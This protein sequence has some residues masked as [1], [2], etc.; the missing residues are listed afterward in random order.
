MSNW[1]S[2]PPMLLWC[3]S[4]R[5]ESDVFASLQ[6]GGHSTS[7]AVG[8]V[9]SADAVFADVL[10]QLLVGVSVADHRAFVEFC[11]LRPTAASRCLLADSIAIDVDCGAGDDF[12]SGVRV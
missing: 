9:L 7:I 5:K 6:S 12:L 1:S 3:A 4:L 2:L 11:Q 8:D 10:L